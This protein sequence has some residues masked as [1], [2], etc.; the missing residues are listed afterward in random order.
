MKWIKDKPEKDGMYFYRTP[1]GTVI[2]GLVHGD[3]F[4]SGGTG[5][6]L[7]YSRVDNKRGEWYGPIVAPCD[8]VK[9]P[10]FVQA[11][12]SSMAGRITSLDIVHDPYSF[13]CS[14]TGYDNVNDKHYI[15]TTSG[16]R[17]IEYGS[18]LNGKIDD[19]LVVQNDI[20]TPLLDRF[21]PIVKNP[22]TPEKDK[23]L[24]DMR[25]VALGLVEAMKVNK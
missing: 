12:Y 5:D 25:T 17:E 8:E 21:R 16:F 1:K 19:A 4:V 3:E 22:P 24:E 18:D 11:E 15:L 7:L 20:I 14:V 9:T 10:P 2:E 13:G 23:H 6:G